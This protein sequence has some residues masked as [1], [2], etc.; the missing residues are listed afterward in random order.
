LQDQDFKESKELIIEESMFSLFISGYDDYKWDACAFSN[1]N[2]NEID[3][4]DEEEEEE[5]ED[6]EEGEGEETS[7]TRDPISSDTVDP[8]YTR[9]PR[10]YYLDV[11][12]ARLHKCFNSFKD[13]VTEVRCSIKVHVS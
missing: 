11:L 10:E 9:N 7:F 13:A 8:E 5:D 12:D 2:A 1:S 6:E 3:S 4:D